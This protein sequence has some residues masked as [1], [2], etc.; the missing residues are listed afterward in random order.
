M[1]IKGN[2]VDLHRR[3]IYYGEIRI[4]NKHIESIKPLQGRS[5]RYIMPGFIDAHVHIESSMLIPTEFARLAVVHGTIATV[6][7]PHEIANVCGMKGVE[8][9]L[10]N[11]VRSPLK[12]HFGAPSCVPATAFETAGA[13]FDS[14]GVGQLL[15][16]PD[17]WYLSE[18]MNYPGVL[19]GDEEVMRKI[20]LA[21]QAG[22]P[23][24]GHA[25]GLRGD[26]AKRYFGAGITTDHECFTY[27]EGREKAEMGVRILIREGSAARNFDALIPLIE[28]FPGQI[29]FCSDD[30]HPDDLILGHINRLAA[31]A[32]DKGYDVM[33]VLRAAC[34]HPVAH[35]GLPVGTLKV[36]DPA[37]FIITGDLRH[38]DIWETWIDGK[39]VAE[40]GVS[41]LKSVRTRR[42]NHFKCRAKRKEQFRIRPT[43][44][45]MRVIRALDGQIVTESFRAPVHKEGTNAISHTATDI[46][47]FAVVNRYRPARPAIGFVHGFGLKQGAIASSIGHD[48]HNILA[49]GTDDALLC[50]A[51]NAII[52]CK[53]GIA[54]LDDR[55]NL[56]VLPLPVGGIMTHHDG[57]ETA[58]QYAEID[59]FTKA[60]LQS[61]LSAP[62]MTLSFMALLVIPELK[63]SDKG[64]FDGRQFS[65]CDLFV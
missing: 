50:E 8:F 4:K 30:K 63:L 64:L 60:Q 39:K 28:T 58:S 25:P 3:Q 37:D 62:F 13:S 15:K 11:A 27:A 1:K 9:M 44:K 23:V 40:K 65:F 32:I 31:R 36:G 5:D 17:I 21:K 18:M 12:F 54:A 10:R 16:R 29:M 47:K 49:V 6:S 35:Y 45:H 34:I 7:D 38:F 57:Y 41:L 56:H 14:R 2:I 48:S 33:D 52:R 22:K 55:G 26:E 46:L 19:F 53:G 24:D 20:A 51:V 42:I 43:K 61:T 59:R